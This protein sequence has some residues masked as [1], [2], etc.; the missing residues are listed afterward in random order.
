MSIPIHIDANGRVTSAA[1]SKLSLSISSATGLFRGAV[2]DP[3]TGKNL[4]FQGA[5]YDDWDVG[6]G[7]FLNPAQSGQALIAPTP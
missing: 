2:V 6:L 7:Y 5:I 4:Q 1:G 3:R